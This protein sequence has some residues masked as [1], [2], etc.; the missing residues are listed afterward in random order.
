MKTNIREIARNYTLKL[1]EGIYKDLNTMVIL[2]AKKAKKGCASVNISRRTT[3][4]QI[5]N[6]M[7]PIFKPGAVSSYSILDVNL[8]R[9]RP[10]YKPSGLA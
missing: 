10:E 2:N 1:G 3:L 7:E 9:S 4:L 8:S 6:N 5:V